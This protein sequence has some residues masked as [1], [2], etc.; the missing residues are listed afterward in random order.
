MSGRLRTVPDGSGRLL[1]G[2]ILT[3]SSAITE[4]P[5]CNS[6]RHN[7]NAGQLEFDRLDF[8]V[9]RFLLKLF[10]SSN[11]GV[12]AEWQRYFR[13]SHPTKLI[14]K[15]EHNYN[16]NYVTFVSIRYCYVAKVFVFT[17]HTL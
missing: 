11:T 12:I 1:V 16:N 7:S 15:N 4:R 10:R 14:A 17:E 13:F 6:T 5:R 3:S 8:A 2:P 9:T